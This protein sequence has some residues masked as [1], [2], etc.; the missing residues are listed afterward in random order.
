LPEE[1]ENLFFAPL[2]TDLVGLFF[3]HTALL[4]R[5]GSAA[6]FPPCAL[7]DEKI[8]SP[9]FGTLFSPRSKENA[10]AAKS[11]AVNRIACDQDLK[12]RIEWRR[13]RPAS[14]KNG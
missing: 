12:F 13:I 7:S 10:K 8:V 3:H 6:I 14:I 11:F 4:R 1:N 2:L 5:S 9:K